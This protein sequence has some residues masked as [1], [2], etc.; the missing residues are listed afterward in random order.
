MYDRCPRSLDTVTPV[1]HERDSKNVKN[2]FKGSMIQN[3]E[4]IELIL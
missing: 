2:I 1:K 4:R 3:G